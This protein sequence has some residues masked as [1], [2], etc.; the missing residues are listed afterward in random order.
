[1]RGVALEQGFY[2]ETSTGSVEVFCQQLKCQIQTD[3]NN[4]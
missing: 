2:C 1:M 3:W 4:E